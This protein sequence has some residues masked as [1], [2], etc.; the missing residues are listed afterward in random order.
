MGK[1][2]S[3]DTVIGV[4]CHKDGLR[5]EGDT[6]LHIHVG[7]E[8]AASPIPGMQPDNE[9]DNIS[10]LNPVYCEL[11][12][13]YWMWRNLPRETAKGLVH[14]RRAFG[15]T[16]SRR[17]MWRRRFHR[18]MRHPVIPML[19]VKSKEFLHAT[20]LG[21]RLA[22]GIVEKGYIVVAEPIVLPVTIG[23]YFSTIGPEFIGMLRD[24]IGRTAPQFSKYL[25]ATLSGNR[26]H[27]GNLS[28]MP[29]PVFDSYCNFL[30]PT[31]G[32][33]LSKMNALVASGEWPPE[34]IKR[35]TGYLA[36][37]LTDS[38]VR[39][40]ADNGHAVVELPVYRLVD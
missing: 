5:L 20:R 30:F 38:F 10:R 29:G 2:T 36:E 26:L 33:V 34:K 15:P 31:L 8:L 7:A 1:R 14:Y 39:H 21:S 24:T 11:T 9:G 13:I 18:M 12:A 28:V 32:D 16:V 27:Y 6:F 22:S 40:A 17:E 3:A 4:A 35:K 25:E 23:E 37:L 19:K